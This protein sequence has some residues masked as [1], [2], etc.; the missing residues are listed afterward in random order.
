MPTPT[1]YRVRTPDGELD[2]PSLLDVERAYAVGLVGP[3][4]EVREE[5]SEKWR[6]AASLPAL[7]RSR[8]APA[9][10]DGG[11]RSQRVPILLA[12]GLSL[13]ALWLLVRGSNPGVRMLGVALAL[14]VAGLLMRVT[15][16]TFSRGKRLL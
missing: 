13:V 9:A 8:P 2:F 7:A 15:S 10:T 4:D 14:V 5:G 12:V 6:R 3:E 1:S 11:S 16:R